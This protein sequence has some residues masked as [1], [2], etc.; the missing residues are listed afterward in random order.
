MHL[1]DTEASGAVRG[2]SDLLSGL[3]PIASHSH[4]SGGGSRVHRRSKTEVIRVGRQGPALLRLL[5]LS[6]VQRERKG[7]WVGHRCHSHYGSYIAARCYERNEIGE[8]QTNSTD[9]LVAICISLFSG[10]RFMNIGRSF[11]T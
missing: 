3:L 10:V 11:Y 8:R 4:E 9:L 7:N 5:Q 6:R 1:T 2:A